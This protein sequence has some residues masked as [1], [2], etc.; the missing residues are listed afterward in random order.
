M[1]IMASAGSVEF[2][3]EANLAKLKQ[4]LENAKKNI[5]SFSREAEKNL[6][7]SPRI[8]I[9]TNAIRTKELGRSISDGIVKGVDTKK[10]ESSG[11]Q[12]AESLVNSVKRV[13]KINSPSKVF[14]DIGTDIVDGLSGGVKG[15]IKS[16]TDNVKGEVG[17][18][19][20]D[21]QKQS[22]TA[23]LS[24]TGLA[25][26]AGAVAMFK[27]E[28]IG[29]GK[30]AIN[31]A[32]AF[33]GLNNTINIVA[34][35]SSKGASK[36]S[37]LKA[38][39][40]E[41]GVDLRTLTSGYSK[42]SAS[43]NN[44]S[45]QG[46]D[47]DNM[48]KAISQAG[49]AYGLSN[50]QMSGAILATSQ[51]AAK[52]TVQM[53]ELRG[54]LA[55]RIPGA[56]G[57]FARGMKMSEQELFKLVATGTVSANDFFT[58]FSKQLMIEIPASSDT[59]RQSFARLGNEITE[60]SMK[61]GQVLLPF[62]SGIAKV[63]TEVLKFA[64]SN[65]DTILK[66]IAVSFGAIA[67]ASVPVI[68]SLTTGLTA[69]AG[70]LGLANAGAILASIGFKGLLAILGPLAV[71][72]GVLYAV[73]ETGGAVF[74][75]LK[76]Q[77]GGSKQAYSDWSEQV[78]ANVEKVNKSL[79]DLSTKEVEIKP[80]R[81]DKNKIV[82]N[83][84]WF[85]DLF[86]MSPENI[87]KSVINANKIREKF[88]KAPMTESE[89]DT[90]RERARSPLGFLGFTRSKGQ[91]E[92]DKA[93]IN[94]AEAGLKSNTFSDLIGSATE[95]Y[96]AGAGPL[97]EV[98][99]IDQAMK[100]LQSKRSIIP[101]SDVNAVKE[102]DAE[103]Q[104]L[105]AERNKLMSPLEGAEAGMRGWLKL[106][107]DRYAEYLQALEDQTSEDKEKR[108]KANAF[109]TSAGNDDASM[110]QVR[111]NAELAS[112]A[113]GQYEQ[114]Q[115]ASGAVNET[116]KLA[117][118]LAELG[119]AFDAIKSHI[120]QMNISKLT[121]LGQIELS[122]FDTD[123]FNSFNAGVAKAQQGV[124][125]LKQ[126]I[127]DRE[128]ITKKLTEDLSISPARQSAIQLISDEE[129]KKGRKLVASEI[130]ALAEVWGQQDTNLKTALESESK[131][132]TE[133]ANTA[134]MKLDLLGQELALKQAIEQQTL[135]G[136]AEERSA[137][138]ALNK[139]KNNDATVSV[140]Q[141]YKEGMQTNINA[142]SD[143]NVASAEQ[144]LI[145]LQANT[146][147]VAKAIDR[148]NQKRLEG[149]L[150]A[151][152][153]NEQIRQL[154]LEQ[155]DL[156]VQTANA[157]ISQIKAV[158]QARADDI[159]RR[160]QELETRINIDN[161]QAQSDIIAKKLAGGLDENGVA[162][163]LAN[164]S[165]AN[166][167][168]LTKALE[169]NRQQ[170][171]SAFVDGAM[172]LRDYTQQVQAIE[173]E[174]VR[175]IKSALEDE[176][177][178]RKAIDQQILADMDKRVKEQQHL[179]Q[180][181]MMQLEEKSKQAELASIT[182]KSDLADQLEKNKIALIESGKAIEQMK[183]QLSEVSKLSPSPENTQK[184]LELERELNQAVLAER[185][186]LLDQQLAIKNKIKDAT[187]MEV[188]GIENQLKLSSE[189]T[190]LE[191]ART[192]QAKARSDIEL[193]ALEG[194]AKLAEIDLGDSGNYEV[195]VKLLD[196]QYAIQQ[197]INKAKS[198]QA[199]ADLVASQNALDVDY[200]REQ[201][202][203][204][205]AEIENRQAVLRAKNDVL[206]AQQSGNQL[207]IQQAKQ[208]L[209]VSSDALAVIVQQQSINNQN[210]GIKKN[211]LGIETKALLAEGKIAKIKEKQA[212][213]QNRINLT[214]SAV[215]KELDKQKT[216]LD[217]IASLSQTVAKAKLN[218]LDKQ[219]GFLDQ[220]LT[221]NTDLKGEDLPDTLRKELR[222]QLDQLTGGGA[223]N[224]EKKLLMDRLALEEKIA[225]EKLKAL[226]QEHAMQKALLQIELTK[227]N[228][229]AQMAVIQ[230]QLLA[231]QLAQNGM[232]KE[233]QQ[234][235]QD[236]LA[237][238]Q[239]M[240]DLGQMA[241][242][243]LLVNQGME[244]YNQQVDN[245]TG[246]NA[247]RR[248][249]AEAGYTPIGARPIM[250][251]YEPPKYKP[252]N[253]DPNQMARD[254]VVNTTGMVGQL[255]EAIG[256]QLE[257]KIEGVPGPASNSQPS[258]YPVNTSTTNQTEPVV[259]NVT[260]NTTLTVISSDPTGDARKVLTDL[261]KANKNRF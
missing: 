27:D 175:L 184:I 239:S 241:M 228:M 209:Q 187:E 205:K 104:K 93:K 157:E 114:A 149:S 253:Y 248:K 156:A 170:I 12:V 52:G 70:K 15:K 109:L 8:R 214:Q 112:K 208:Q 232:A 249:V 146:N 33:E 181:E 110:E 163:A 220:A 196:R 211:T 106:N 164:L 255:V 16:F 90:F 24:F 87:E 261:T 36:F 127:Q 18:L 236:A 210:Y 103:M 148:L 20:S 259:N 154:S 160:K 60:I 39:A 23:K 186:T 63:S 142:E 207:A 46:P 62:A 179:F 89:V 225:K 195:S 113:L 135:A 121:E 133:S 96:K 201:L 77:L 233:G 5:A 17:N 218:G 168:E 32:I 94:L 105:N 219:A 212:Q 81:L 71:K 150:S 213:I 173:L 19:V 190:T 200:Q 252:M 151:E 183:V 147:E 216:R 161:T 204:R 188:L 42:L 230:A 22:P 166:N 203:L 123:I 234:L 171:E 99:K 64:S 134:K 245:F 145:S 131:L 257:A 86:S 254:A 100:A 45:L 178:I 174:R 9:N 242:D 111:I 240:K 6:T 44:T 91:N 139:I 165:K 35:S 14:Y 138:Q 221:L 26:G 215:T 31:T 53:E 79:L 124:A 153:Y 98:A 125:S 185:L 97:A 258:T 158:Q 107:Q 43:T 69:I 197:S 159:A 169:S 129:L 85:A 229:A 50:E 251:Q 222:G 162:I 243:G 227:Q 11:K 223:N 193:K 117:L 101:A 80:P 115:K 3:L 152:K 141:S 244:R 57:I 122:G 137:L 128:N 51:I 217:A 34:G 198:D 108:D 7:L 2:Q 194:R 237:A 61:A 67:M 176:V 226:E 54:Q 29:L 231:Q 140:A 72:A 65:F 40:S 144:A 84:N 202:T 59:A 250:P 180:M 30:S 78:T 41:L 49:V 68:A 119:S 247:E 74:N 177:N 83:N 37:E 95:K 130:D 102:L 199:K 256:K 56:V 58:K 10:V 143:F 55:E 132:R 82:N 189:L 235:I 38:L 224:N 126:E 48:I 167:Q 28:I 136:L 73:L 120:D 238:Q 66:G 92:A 182:P 75:L 13:L 76:D 4:D 191:S 47:T 21:I 118:A 260:N 1:N 116:Q 88:G 172:N 206:V 155:S 246:I 25:V 192:A